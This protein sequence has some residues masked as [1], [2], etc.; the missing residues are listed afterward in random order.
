MRI[1]NNRLLILLISF[2]CF[3]QYS[4][5]QKREYLFNNISLN[6]AS[7]VCSM[8]QDSHGIV[9]IGTENGLFSYDGYHSYAHFRQGGKENTRINAI[10]I[11]GDTAYL[12]SNVGL[13]VYDIGRDRYINVK[14]SPKD[15]RAI[16]RFNNCLTIG[17]TNGL[18]SFECRS[19]KFRHLKVTAYVYALMKQKNNQLFIGTIHGLYESDHLSGYGKS[20]QIAHGRQPLVN[21]LMRDVYGKGAWIGTEGNLYYD[22]GKTM[23]AVS[24]LKGNSIKSLA[25]KDGKI[26]VGT[27]NGLYEYTPS[28]GNKTKGTAY[29]IA[30]DSRNKKSLA[31]NIVWT[32]LTDKWN[33]LWVGTDN[34]L[35]MLARDTY[36]SFIPI[37]HVT[38]VGDGNCLHAILHSPDGMMWM[39]GTNGLIKFSD[40]GLYHKEG[41]ARGNQ[42]IFLDPVWYRQ[43]NPTEPLSHNRVRKVYAD[44]DGDVI[45]CTDHGLNIYNKGTKQFQNVIVTDKKGVYTSA[46][47]YDVVEDSYGRYWIA[48]Y[49]GGI[50]VISKKRLKNSTGYVIADKHFC[51]E[52][53]GVH[54][55]QL[56]LDVNKNVYASLYEHGIDRINTLTMRV[57]HVLRNE[58]VYYLTADKEGRVFAATQKGVRLFSGEGGD[59]LIY[60]NTIQINNLVVTP[61]NLWIVMGGVC[62]VLAKNGGG[63]FFRLPNFTPLTGYY[64]SSSQMIYFGGDDGFMTI[65]TRAVNN[66][67]YNRRLI[68]SGM[69]VN[70]KPYVGDGVSVRNMNSITLR[71]DQNNIVLNLTDI[72][73]SGQLASV[74]MYKL[75]G[76]DHTWQYLSGNDFD[77][78]YNGLP[79]GR[80]HLSVCKVGVGGRM[81]EVYSFDIHI[82]PPW[83]FTWWAFLLY[84]IIIAILA[85]WGR[86]FYIVKHRLV[87]ERKAKQ[88]IMKQSETRASVFTEL[89]SSMVHKLNA[90]ENSGEESSLENSDSRL[91]AEVTQAIDEH[92][93]DT[94]LSVKKLQEIVGVGDKLLYR[95]LKSLTG[96]TPVEYIRHIRMQRAANLLRESS[97][98]VSEVMYMVGFSSSSYFSKCFQNT[99]GV[100][101]AEYAK[102]K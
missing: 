63:A 42:H 46:W 68:L 11:I 80:Y 81:Q 14:N 25:S 21:A 71:Y 29:Y 69:M 7:V 38:G 30:H 47:A 83:Y 82:L 12:G 60:E 56:V 77:I 20:L 92:L 99:F 51:M 43:N 23:E 24:A 45:V 98:T 72:P 27:D 100:T 76:I 40:A 16:A 65:D 55:G 58:N 1:H 36:F 85:R 101:P 28:A 94:D 15:I 6:G 9:W 50:F 79:Y 22:D 89:Y 35:S 93:A 53:Q 34:G 67:Q 17:G 48:A 31:N 96:K 78:S 74:Y 32:L 64:D 26:F 44:R 37:D 19:M 4:G 18:Y 5:A 88:H 10:Y 62:C 3:V 13:L 75:D 41:K 59:K 8:S 61:Y 86:N 70:G 39:G 73:F 95:K 54:V 2:I 52:L 91:L 87:E 33:N 102:N 90:P 84:M 49:M 66:I 57:S 97:C